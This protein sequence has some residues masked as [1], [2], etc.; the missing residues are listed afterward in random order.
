VLATLLYGCESS[1]DS[2]RSPRGLNEQPGTE[3]FSTVVD[4]RPAALVDGRAVLW[5]E[6]RAAMT[7]SAGA[8]ALQDVILDRKLRPA[9]ASARIEITDEAV[10]AERTMLVAALSDDPIIAV[11]LL[12]ELRDRQNLGP[13][14]FDALMRR[15][16]MLRALIRNQVRI[17]ES[18]IVALHDARHG[19]KRRV[20]LITTSDLSSAQKAISRTRAGAFFGDVAVEVSTDSSASRGGLLLPVSRLD[21]SY[22]LT[23]RT[24]IWRLR[25]VGDTSDAILMDSGYAV[26][27]LV[28]IVE[29]DGTDRAAIHDEL[30]RVARRNQERVLMD[31]LAR[32]L[33]RGTTVTVFDDSLQ[34]SWQRAR[35]TAR[36]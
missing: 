13:A 32:D 29:A 31:Q 2:F 3:G 17:D 18:T 6:L 20:R 12:E 11:R 7:E 19:P 24:A 21:P 25:N 22:P 16:A 8:A 23:L 4:A 34:D 10:E 5:G 26:V 9:V 1:P 27:Q 15:N 36:Q 30:E 14:R 35:R 33:V 28:E